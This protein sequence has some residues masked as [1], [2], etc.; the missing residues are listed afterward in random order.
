MTERPILFNGAMVRALLAGAKTQTRRVIPYFDGS[1]YAKDPAHV[2]WQRPRSAGPAAWRNK[3]YAYQRMSGAS[4]LPVYGLRCPY[5]QPGDQLWVRERHHLTLIEGRCSENS[6]ATF[7][8]GGQKYRDGA[9]YVPGQGLRTDGLKWRPSIHMPRWACR[10]VL[11]VT[12]VRVERLQDISAQDARAEGVER[13]CRDPHHLTHDTACWV[14]AY[15]RLWDS[16]NFKRGYG[17]AKNPFVWV[18]AFK[19]WEKK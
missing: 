6:F 14:E 19:R 17:W 15:E 3:W 13:D 1:C 5:G 10:L 7:V 8:D 12:A 11:E 16:L 18:V 4:A 2:R 9:Y